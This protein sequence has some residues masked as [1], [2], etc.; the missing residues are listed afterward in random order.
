MAISLQKPKGL[1]SLDFCGQR[2]NGAI[3]YYRMPRLFRSPG[4]RIL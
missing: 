1:E 2:E 4:K 3:H